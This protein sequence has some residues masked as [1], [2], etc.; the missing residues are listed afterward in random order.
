MKER[1]LIDFLSSYFSYHSK[2][3]KTSQILGIGD[4]AAIFE[5]EAPLVVTSDAI[6]YS[7]HVFNLLSDKDIARRFVTAN[8]SDLASMGS[9]PLYFVNNLLFSEE[10][11]DKVDPKK[12]IEGIEEGCERYDMSVIGGDISSARELVLSGFAIGL[13]DKGYLTREDAE[14]GDLLCVTGDLGR[15][16]AGFEIGEKIPEPIIEKMVDP[17]AR[18]EEGRK[19]L[20]IATSCNDISDGLSVES[21]EISK[22]SNVK[23]I[24]DP[25]KFPIHESVLKKVKNPKETVLSSGEE[26]EL[27]FTI[28]QDKI[29]LIDFEFTVIG[30]VKKGSGVYLKDGTKVRQTGWQHFNKR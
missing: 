25:D 7:S 24:L 29:D 23:I 11:E 28:P 5:S 12:I 16:K 26:F 3:D 13:A 17:E 21:W 4:D 2:S 22:S 19:L 14:P 6:S 30:K 20:D 18:V 10:S 1:E 8:V 15:V 9:S 27:L